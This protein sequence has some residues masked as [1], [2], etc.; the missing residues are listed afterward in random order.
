M[1]Q[2]MLGGIKATERPD[3]CLRRLGISVKPSQ[4]PGGYT[5]VL[6][7]WFDRVLRGRFDIA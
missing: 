2:F 3:D 4:A 5:V 7:R 6:W 1:T